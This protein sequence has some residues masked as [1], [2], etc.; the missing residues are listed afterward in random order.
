MR[1]RRLSIPIVATL[2]ASFLLPATAAHATDPPWADRTLFVAESGQRTGNGGLWAV[3]P[4]GTKTLLGSGSAEDVA[5]AADGT[6]YWVECSGGLYR[7]TPGAGSAVQIATPGNCPTSVAL[8]PNGD[9]AVGNFSGIGRYD[10]STGTLLDTISD[11]LTGVSSMTFDSQSDLYLVDGSGRLVVWPAAGDPV[12]VTGITN[13]GTSI[14]SVR[15][16]P[17]YSWIA[18]V[19][20]EHAVDRINVDGLH[21][22]FDQGYYTDGSAVDNTGTI[23]A[24]VLQD[25]PSTQDYVSRVDTHDGTSPAVATGF[26]TPKGLA[27]W[28]LLKLAARAP[29]QTALNVSASSVTTVGAE[30]LTATVTGVP[31]GDDGLLQF[32]VGGQ[33]LGDAVTVR[34]GSASLRI[35][36]PAGSDDVQATYLGNRTVLP[37][38]SASSVVT[39]SALRTTTT[40]STASTTVQQEFQVAVTA[41]V[42]AVRSGFATPTGE[43]SFYVNGKFRGFYEPDASGDATAPNLSMNPGANTV[44]AVYSG[45]SIYA[46]SSGQLSITAVPPF[47]AF[48]T[49]NVRYLAVNANGSQHVSIRV[50]VSGQHGYATPTGTITAEGQRFTCTTAT[51][52]AAKLTATCTGSAPPGSSTVTLD[53]SGDDVYGGFS[54]PQSLF[55][56][57]EG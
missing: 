57:G 19:P 14:A 2:S 54:A 10:A 23:Y 33:P 40:L 55:V 13:G 39:V 49:T 48:L 41:H 8:A 56:G 38:Q 4:I 22:G 25:D 42:A 53:Y 26:D 24:S 17:A 6:V 44:R 20:F 46:G 37:S 7:Y 11:T 35:T 31:T 34:N 36:L 32:T 43:V 50:L 3:A 5:V 21:F 30:T 12:P 15:L 47:Q 18:S 16:G 29:S 28:P 45:D 51:I 27:S 9:V 52:V 1:L